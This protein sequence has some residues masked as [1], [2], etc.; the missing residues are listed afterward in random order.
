VHVSCSAARRVARR[1]HRKA[2]E[3]TPPANGIRRFNWRGW[4]VTGDL[5]PAKDR[6]IA[7]KNEHRVRWR[8]G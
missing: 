3:M 8:F 1:A 5:R 7:R 2:L 4:K 6:Y